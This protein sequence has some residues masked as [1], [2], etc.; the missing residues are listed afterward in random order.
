MNMTLTR[1]GFGNAAGFLST[2]VMPVGI[3]VLVAMMVLP[4]PAFLLDTFFVTNAARPECSVDAD[5]SW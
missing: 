1:F 3:L 5:H 2:L 4:L